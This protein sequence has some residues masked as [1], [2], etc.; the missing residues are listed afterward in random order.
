M[1]ENKHGIKVHVSMENQHIIKGKLKFISISF[2]TL[3]LRIERAFLL[4]HDL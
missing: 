4:E 1:S 2:Q 3:N